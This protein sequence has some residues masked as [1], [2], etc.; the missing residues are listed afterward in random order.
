MRVAPA[1]RA[2]AAQAAMLNIAAEMAA[3]Q[4]RYHIGRLKIGV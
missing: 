2:R 4:K 3:N 1:K